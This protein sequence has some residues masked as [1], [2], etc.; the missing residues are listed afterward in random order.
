MPLRR[1]VERGETQ[2]RPDRGEYAARCAGKVLGDGCALPAAKI[3]LR[4]APVIHDHRYS[5]AEVQPARERDASRE[6]E[7]RR[8]PPRGE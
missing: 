8:H 2:R 3:R 6:V 1:R 4:E 5:L 7:G